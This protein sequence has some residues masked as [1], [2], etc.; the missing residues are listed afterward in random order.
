MLLLMIMVTSLT[1]SNVNAQTSYLCNPSA[2]CGCSSSS[3]RVSRILG[4]E[5]AFNHTWGWAVSILF[6]NTHYCGG[7]LI[8]SSWIVTTAGCIGPYRA[9]EIVVSAATNQ[10]FGWQQWRPAFA[11]FPHQNFD[12]S[13]FVNNIALIE[14][15]PPFNMNDSSIAQICLPMAT[16]EDYPPVNSSVSEYHPRKRWTFDHFVTCFFS[17]KVDCHRLGIDYTR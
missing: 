7:T 14:V 13:S 15:S 6:N 8:S 16:T 9:W 11:V 3:A 2:P 1:S 5:N 12:P 4:G 17:P 10:L